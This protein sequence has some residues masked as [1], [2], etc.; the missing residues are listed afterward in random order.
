MGLAGIVSRFLL[1]IL[2]VVFGLNGFFHFLPM[3]PPPTGV[4]GNYIGAL[5][6]S[7]AI[8]VVFA[9]EI[10]GGFLLVSGFFVR[11]AL[12]VLG[13]LLANILIYH[14]FMARNGLLM[15]LVF[16]LLWLFT[17][18]RDEGFF[19]GIFMVKSPK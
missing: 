9:T 2:F 4:A 8:K 18:F 5:V 11:M 1:G 13:C 12:L 17:S 3:P 19:G 10:I 16:T 6:T 14:F 7:G 15:A